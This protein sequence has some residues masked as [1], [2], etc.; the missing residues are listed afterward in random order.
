MNVTFLDLLEHVIYK[1]CNVY[2]IIHYFLERLEFR[3]CGGRFPECSSSCRKH[4]AVPF[5]DLR[6]CKIAVSQSARQC[7]RYVA[8]VPTEQHLVSLFPHQRNKRLAGI[9]STS[10][11]AETIFLGI[12]ENVSLIYSRP[13]LPQGVAERVLLLLQALFEVSEDA[14]KKRTSVP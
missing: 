10:E 7:R 2:K 8:K 6:D 9:Y 14:S 12:A 13:Y 5:L 11:A 3:L 1:Y 4:N